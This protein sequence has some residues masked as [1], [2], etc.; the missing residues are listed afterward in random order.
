MHKAGFTKKKCGGGV[1]IDDVTQS[2]E[3]VNSKELLALTYEVHFGHWILEHIFNVES[4]WKGEC[5]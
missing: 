4:G 2:M 3:T 1:I 5:Y